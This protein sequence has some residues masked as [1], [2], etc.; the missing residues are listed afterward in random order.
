M[1]RRRGATLTHRALILVLAILAFACG[2]LAVRLAIEHRR[3]VC[4]RATAQENIAQ[5]EGDCDR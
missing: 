4:W 5:P 3:L 2:A 1:L